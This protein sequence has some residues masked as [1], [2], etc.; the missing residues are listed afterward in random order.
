MP[1][2]TRAAL[3]AFIALARDART[4]SAMLDQRG[5]LQLASSEATRTLALAEY[6]AEND[7]EGVPRLLN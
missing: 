2:G 3:E 6:A 7:L 4:V 1:E 5:V